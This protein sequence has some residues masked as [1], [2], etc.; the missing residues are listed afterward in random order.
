M[1]ESRIWLIHMYVDTVAVEAPNFTIW[2]KSLDVQLAH[3]VTRSNVSL[4]HSFICKC[5]STVAV[6]AQAITIC[7][8]GLIEWLVEMSRRSTHSYVCFY[9]GSGGAS[10]HNF[11]QMAHWIRGI[12][13]SIHS[14]KDSYMCVLCLQGVIRG[15]WL[16]ESL[17]YKRALQKRSI[18]CKQTNSSFNELIESLIQ[19][20]HWKTHSCVCCYCGSGSAERHYL[21]RRSGS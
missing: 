8:K 2:E 14:L 6:K 1:I 15:K 12:T 16:I 4:K 17:I 21:G 19:M 3:L 7:G 9:N 11:G 18:F 20:T 10:H 13:H 5:V